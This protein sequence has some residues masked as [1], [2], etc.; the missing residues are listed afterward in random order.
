MIFFTPIIVKYIGKNLDITKCHYGE[1]YL[2]V[3][4]PFIISKLFE[5]IKEE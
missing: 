5:S 2:P 1:Y 4:W 3:P